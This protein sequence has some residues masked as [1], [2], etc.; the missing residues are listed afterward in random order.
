MNAD[1][2]IDAESVYNF[3]LNNLNE[4][5]SIEGFA[6][7]PIKLGG[8]YWTLTAI[9][10][11]KG[12]IND[13]L[14]PKAGR[15]L[16]CLAL[17]TINGSRNTDGG[18]GN[19][20]GHPSSVIATHYAILTLCLLGK[21]STIEKE[22][23]TKYIMRLQNADG[24][25]NS[26]HLGEADARHVYSSII[27][28]S[29]LGALDRIDVGKTTEFLLS[30]QNANGGFG[31]YPEG[32]SHAAASFCC[33][34]ALC[35]LGTI[36]LANV[37]ALGI[38]L[39]ERQTAG[40]GCNGRAEKAPDICYSWWVLSALSNI[41]RFDWFD[42]EKLVEFIARSQNKE[43][44]GIAYFPGFIGDVF[45]TFFALAALSLLEHNRFDLISIHPRYATTT[46]G[47]KGLQNI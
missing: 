21:Q 4:R 33:V 7:E 37:D 22:L 11:L 45:H 30:C 16:E 39:A 24:S 29:V 44:G 13:I 15:S 1:S 43:D 32:E 42:K 40:G 19:A 17:E 34:G 20:P 25:F 6:Y 14:H 31:W 38:W 46:Y 10:L 26:D 27:C 5:L 18:F 47:M 36:H 23:T 2:H 35:E 8:L 12:E 9:S 3:L 28:L 41:G